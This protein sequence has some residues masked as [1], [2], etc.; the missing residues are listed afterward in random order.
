M[1]YV[2]LI[3]DDNTLTTT[4]RRRIMQREKLVNTLWFLTAPEYNGY[5]MSEFTV[6]MEYVLPC[7]RRYKTEILELNKEGYKEF[8]KYTLPF[9]TEL[10]S[11]AGEI[12]VQLTFVCA[13]LD[14]NGNNIQRVRKTS[15]CK[16][17][18]IPLSNW[19]DIIPDNALSSLDQRLIKLDAAMKAMNG[20]LDVVDNNMVDDLAYDDV[21]ETL[22]LTAK[23]KGVGHKV[24][25]KDMLEDGTPV[26]DLDSTSGDSS[27]SGNDSDKE[28]GNNCNCGCNCEDDVVEF[29]YSETTNTTDSDVVEF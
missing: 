22:Q 11:E 24:S 17:N 6:V 14:E 4:Q 20:Y 5:D 7:S 3:N 21:E 8:L 1:D 19:S 15:K 23:G 10:T 29:G 26:V 18:I 16:I 13:D 2:I 9:D 25:I 28:H 27:D 12:E